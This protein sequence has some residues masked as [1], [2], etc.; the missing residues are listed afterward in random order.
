MKTG[1]PEQRDEAQQADEPDFEELVEISA[2][3][4]ALPAREAATASISWTLE[5]YGRD[6]V[7]ASSF[8]DVV[9]VDLVRKA[10][11]GIEIVFLD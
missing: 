8:Q 1:R 4:E 5:R 11:P 7:V 3:C 6:V 9:L 2:R 10:D